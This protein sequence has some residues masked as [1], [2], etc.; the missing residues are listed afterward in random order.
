[1]IQLTE[2]QKRAIQNGD[3]PRLIDPDTRVEYVLVPA[4]IYENMKLKTS[5]IEPEATYPL[6]DEVM[7]EDW[8]DPQMAE[9][10]DYETHRS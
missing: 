7:R 3:A 1:M 2:E 6:V 9:Y 8:D 10:D 4:E 5:D